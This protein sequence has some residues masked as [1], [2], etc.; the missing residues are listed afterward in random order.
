MPTPDEG[1]SVHSGITEARKHHQIDV[2]TGRVAPFAEFGRQGLV[3]LGKGLR[4]EILE[5]LMHQIQGVVDQLGGL[6]GSHG[7]SEE[8]RGVDMG[9]L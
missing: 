9:P 6:F 7:T 2:A 5:A 4:L 8:G 3:L 1:V